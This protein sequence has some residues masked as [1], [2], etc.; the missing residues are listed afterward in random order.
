MLV[1][2]LVFLPVPK[3]Y[4]FCDFLFSSLDDKP[5]PKRA[6]VIAGES[7]L[8]MSKFFSFGVE[9][10]R[11]GG[12]NESGRIASPYRVPIYLKPSVQVLYN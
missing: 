11:K 1:H 5:L 9:P 2:L 10:I 7:C 3:G 4:N 6:L 8:K 12:E